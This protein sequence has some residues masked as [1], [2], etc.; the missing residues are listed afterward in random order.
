MPSE[1]RFDYLRGE[2]VKDIKE[3][4]G[5]F[6]VRM[7]TKIAQFSRKAHFMQSHLVDH[8]DVLVGDLFF[9][10][11]SLSQGLIKKELADTV[12]PQLFLSHHSKLFTKH[13]ERWN[14]NDR[15]GGVLKCHDASEFD[16]K[17]HVESQDENESVAEVSSFTAD[18]VRKV[19]EWQERNEEFFS[20]PARS[21]CSFGSRLDLPKHVNSPAVIE[22]P[23]VDEFGGVSA[24]ELRRML[25][26][27]QAKQVKEV[28]AAHVGRRVVLPAGSSLVAN[29]LSSLVDDNFVS[30]SQVGFGCG[31]ETDDFEGFEVS[32]QDSVDYVAGRL[33]KQNI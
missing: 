25:E 31:D 33:Q 2:L 12:P 6:P 4:W 15:T 26:I 27:Q 23:Q 17:F 20:A 11:E 10:G 1:K 32:A 22:P 14:D 24:K 9:E 13:I 3:R 18:C 7:M 28:K 5:T 21:E 19:R 29:N 8:P 30:V 16:Y